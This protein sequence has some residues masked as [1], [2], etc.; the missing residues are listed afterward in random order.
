MKK[1]LLLAAIFFMLTSQYR[2]YAYATY[3]WEVD[4]TN[5]PEGRQTI[6]MKNTGSKVHAVKA[7]VIGYEAN[8]TEIQLNSYMV[9]KNVKDNESLSFE[10]VPNTPVLVVKITWRDELMKMKSSRLASGEKKTF[11]VEKRGSKIKIK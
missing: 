6:T 3:R 5:I 9:R 8:G 2:A 11:V 4:F 7:D 1:I 10:D